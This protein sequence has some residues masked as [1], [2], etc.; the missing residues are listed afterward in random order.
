MRALAYEGFA[1]IQKNLRFLHPGGPVIISV[2][3]LR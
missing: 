1:D 3:L 2:M